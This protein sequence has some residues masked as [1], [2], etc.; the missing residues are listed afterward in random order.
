MQKLEAGLVW[1]NCHDGVINGV[2][3]RYMPKLRKMPATMKDLR[4]SLKNGHIQKKTNGE[5][6]FH[7]V[8]FGV[9]PDG[10]LALGRQIWVKKNACRNP[11]H[12]SPNVLRFRE[13]LTDSLSNIVHRLPT[14]KGETPLTLIHPLP[15]SLEN[16]GNGG[17]SSPHSQC[18]QARTTCVDAIARILPPRHDTCQEDLPTGRNFLSLCPG[19]SKCPAFRILYGMKRSGEASI[20]SRIL[21][22]DDQSHARGVKLCHG[23]EGKNYERQRLVVHTNVTGYDFPPPSSLHV[24]PSANDQSY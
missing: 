7:P 13:M 1:E 11:H 14:K 5:P 21:M 8:E 3:T 24:A 9:T 6:A 22:W 20:F 2:L 10:Q 18:R 23:D 17:R 16:S 12:P 15:E 4:R 19:V